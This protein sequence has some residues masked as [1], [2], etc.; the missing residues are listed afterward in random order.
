MVEPGEEEEVLEDVLRDAALVVDAVLLVSKLD[1]DVLADVGVVVP[2]VPSPAAAAE[3][4]DCIC[5]VPC[6]PLLDPL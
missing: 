5:M 4:V 6:S 2:L 1:A 3:V